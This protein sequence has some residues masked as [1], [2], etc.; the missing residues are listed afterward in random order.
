MKVS[1]AQ[2]AENRQAILE[3]AARLYRERGLAG[4]GVAEISR[5]AGFT[6]GGFYGRFG[7]KQQLAAEACEQAF[8]I[9]LPRLQASLHRHGGDARPFFEGYLS[10]RHRDAPATGCPMPALAVDAARETGPVPAA[11]GSG[12]GA[13][14]QTLARHR[15]DGSIA[16]APGA[17][18]KARAIMSLAALVGGMVLARATAEAAPALS[19]EI[20][21]TLQQQLG[22]FWLKNKEG[23]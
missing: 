14:L 8:A 15:P 3:A 1:K 5:E 11:L 7:S 10:A 23:A 9:S 19:D 2:S 6:H 16:D 4:V 22:E 13:Y 17:G 21:A 12:I 20:L 18:D